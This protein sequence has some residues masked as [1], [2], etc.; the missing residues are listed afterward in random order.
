VIAPEGPKALGFLWQWP[1]D[2]YRVVMGA[3]APIQKHKIL[4]LPVSRGFRFFIA[5]SKVILF[6]ALFLLGVCQSPKP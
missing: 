6:Y 3:F 4:F 5:L 2:G 1:N